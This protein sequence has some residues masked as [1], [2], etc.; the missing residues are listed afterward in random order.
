METRA[1]GEQGNVC[2]GVGRGGG[3]G[4]ESPSPLLSFKAV[5]SHHAVLETQP[6][7]SAGEEVEGSGTWPDDLVLPRL[8]IRRAT[9][10]QATWTYKH[11]VRASS[12]GEQEVLE[13]ST[14]GICLLHEKHSR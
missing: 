9:L 14:L 12:S 4:A 6:T 10:S 1:A 5:H 13:K 11:W 3:V 8:P 2:A 7:G